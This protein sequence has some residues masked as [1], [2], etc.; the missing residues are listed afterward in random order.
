M[1]RP[2]AERAVYRPSPDVVARHIAGQHL[3]VPV[4]TG[5]A[6]MDCLYTAG[7]VGSFVYAQIDG[8]REAREVARRVCAVFDVDEDRAL[9]DVLD[10]LEALH[11]AGIIREGQAAR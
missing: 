10:F 1:S 11:A 7:E 5:M 8:R 6:Q 9:A 4:R 3:F 2:G